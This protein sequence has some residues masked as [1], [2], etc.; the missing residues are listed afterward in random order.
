MMPYTNHG[1]TS[2]TKRKSGQRP[3]LSVRDCRGL[4]L[5]NRK[6]TAAKMTTELN[7]HPEDP[8]SMKTMRQGLHKSN[9]YGR[10][11]IAK[12]LITENNAEQQKRWCDVHKTWMCDDRKYEIWSD[13]S[14]F[15]LFPS[16]QVYV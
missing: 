1:K 12:P 11:A 5:N 4:Y 16:F 15:S 3:K 14:S 6:T 9:I 7:I 13:E 10:A 2:S 8:V